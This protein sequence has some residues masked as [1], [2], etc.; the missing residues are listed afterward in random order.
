MPHDRDEDADT[1]PLVRR[2]RRLVSSPRPLLALAA[3]VAALA[4][5]ARLCS[6]PRGT[7]ELP[8]RCEA[9]VA[10]PSGQRRRFRADA[11]TLDQRCRLPPSSLLLPYCYGTRV[12][13]SGLWSVSLTY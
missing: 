4:S 9:E 10:G 5:S 3:S 7:V 11:S 12:R 6:R 1:S 13:K 8:A 2:T